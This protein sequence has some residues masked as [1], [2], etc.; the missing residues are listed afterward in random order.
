MKKRK[1]FKNFWKF[2]KRQVCSLKI[3]D[4]FAKMVK[5]DILDF[6]ARTKMHAL[7]TFSLDAWKSKFLKIFKILKILDKFSSESFFFF[8]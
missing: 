3:E 2:C 8:F 6:F 4:I 5:M 7:G 1:I